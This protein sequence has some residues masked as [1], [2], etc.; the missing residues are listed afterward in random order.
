MILSCNSCE[1]KFVVPDSAITASGRLVQCSACGNKWKQFP[2]TSESKIE[3]KTVEIDYPHKTKKT[4]KNI[5]KRT[6][7]KLY[8][9]EYLIQ[10]HGI[11]INKESSNKKKKIEDKEKINFGFYKLLIISVII[12]IFFLR[13]LY[14]TQEIIIETF[15]LS[16]IYIDYLFESIENIKEI[17][18]NFLSSY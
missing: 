8:S 2:T 11:K 12:V 7:P 9:P 16:G 1:K 17:V 18:K 10:K 15:P 6:G 3:E 14:L 4:K 5:K 13:T